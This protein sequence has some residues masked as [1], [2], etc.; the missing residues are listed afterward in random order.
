MQ[1]R[2]GLYPSV[3]LELLAWVGTAVAV[4]CSNGKNGAV[5][6][7][8]AEGS[9]DP[10]LQST[11]RANGKLEPAT[12]CYGPTLAGASCYKLISGSG[13]TQTVLIGWLGEGSDYLFCAVRFRGVDCNC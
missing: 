6:C 7:P 2:L 5:T 12:E 10:T 8:N 9:V 11:L 13:S 4:R 3:A 1:L